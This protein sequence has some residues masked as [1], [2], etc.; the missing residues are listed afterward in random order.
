MMP[1]NDLGVG[2][3]ELPQNAVEKAWPPVNHA[4]DVCTLLRL[5]W[6]GHDDVRINQPPASSQPKEV[7]TRRPS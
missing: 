3:D 5:L 4:S 1:S 7:K 2:S 6:T